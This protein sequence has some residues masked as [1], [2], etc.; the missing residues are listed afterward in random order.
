MDAGTPRQAAPSGAAGSSNFRVVTLP[1]GPLQA[2]C[3]LLLHPDSGEAC[4]IDPGAEEQRILAA[5]PRGV[6]VRYVVATHAHFDHVGAVA[7]VR[8]AVGAPFLLHPADLELLRQ[9]PDAAELYTG[10]RVPA[11]PEPDGLL[12][13]GR[14]LALGPLVVEVRH[15]PGHSPGSVSL[16]VQ[17]QAEA[18]FSGDALFAGSIGR[19]DLPGGDLDQLL[20]SIRRELLS[21]ADA[22]V[23]YPGHGPTSTVGH[24]RRTNPF[25]TGQRP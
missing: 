21:L 18:V 9:A 19:T 1:V 11:P 17:G 16:Y 3:Y 4:L 7:P 12:A 23:V 13:H 2:N 24:E 14:Q 6:R 15:T 8:A 25:L 20:G 22:A 10:Q 5:I